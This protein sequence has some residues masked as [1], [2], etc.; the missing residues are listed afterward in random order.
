MTRSLNTCRLVCVF[1]LYF[2]AFPMAAAGPVPA[3]ASDLEKG[4]ALYRAHDC[5]AAIPFLEAANAAA[6]KAASTI[7]LGT[8]YRQQHRFSKADSVLRSYL[9][10]HPEDETRVRSMLAQNDEEK[11][12]W[13]RTHPNDVE[14][15]EPS[16]PVATA[17]SA[18]PVGA[19]S[20][21][22]GPAPVSSPQPHLDAKAE[23]PAPVP[24]VAVVATPVA[25]PRSHSALPWITAGVAVAALGTGLA[26]GLS[27]RSSA[28]ELTS[29]HHTSAE[30]TQLDAD[31]TSKARTGNILLG[32]GAGL[33]AVSAGLFLFH[34]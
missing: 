2:A 9:K 3:S 32:V 29:A 23:P 21:S 24:A 10:S 22:A 7:A 30:V 6:P 18:A 13:H 14:A 19:L 8:C 12:D 11:R 1:S 16:A 5:R 4:L 17:V 31:V 26:F 20:S 27:S 28:N 25:E 33:A 34:F 15:Q